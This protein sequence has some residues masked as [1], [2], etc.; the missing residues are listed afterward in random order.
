MSTS[1]SQKKSR[2]P[3]LFIHPF[4]LSYLS[5]SSVLSL[6]RC[7]RGTFRKTK[8]LSSWRNRFSTG[9]QI[10][11]ALTQLHTR[12]CTIRLCLSRIY[13]RIRPSSN[14]VLYCLGSDFREGT[15]YSS[16]VSTFRPLLDDFESLFIYLVGPNMTLSSSFEYPHLKIVTYRGLFHEIPSTFFS[17]S[18]SSNTIHLAVAF[19]A[20]IWGYDTWKPTIRRVCH[21]MDVPLL[22]TSYNKLESED[23]YDVLCD[24][25]M[26]LSF[27]WGPPSLNPFGSLLEW[28]SVYD[29]ETQSDNRYWLLCR[30]SGLIF[31]KRDDDD[32]DG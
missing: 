30:S 3:F 22:I 13:K 14:L 24:D 20:G 31:K 21:E 17:S 6:S 25:D 11:S 2:P 29:G 18:S 32:D 7:S 5:L 28:D 15:S 27:P 16:V 23:D 10:T 12:H 4:L 26:S 9:G 19:N 1:P 8:V